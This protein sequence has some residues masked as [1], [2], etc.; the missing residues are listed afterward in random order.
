M[1]PSFFEN[2]PPKIKVT[3]KE[4]F[5][6]DGKTEVNAYLVGL[7]T[8]DSLLFLLFTEDDEGPAV[9]VES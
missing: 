6:A 1:T 9:F 7:E 2:V 5:S 3:R 8:L 4:N